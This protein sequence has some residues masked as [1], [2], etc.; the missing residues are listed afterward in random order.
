[1]NMANDLQ[2]QNPKFLVFYHQMRRQ[3]ALNLKTTT[4]LK[5][6]EKKTKTINN[7]M[8]ACSFFQ[9]CFKGKQTQY[10]MG[11]INGELIAKYLNLKNT[12]MY[13]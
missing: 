4:H 9:F 1:M 12:H 5:Y 11:N 10:T 8:P 7:R 6:P 13:H 3:V 2:W